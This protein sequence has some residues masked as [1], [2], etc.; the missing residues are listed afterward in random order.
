MLQLRVIRAGR[1]PVPEKLPARWIFMGRTPSLESDCERILGPERRVEAAERLQGLAERLRPEFARHVARIG[2]LQADLVGWCSSSFAWKHTDV[3]ALFRLSCYRLLIKAFSEETSS[4]EELLVLVED[5]WLFADCRRDPRLVGRVVF[6]GN[7]HLWSARA[8]FL[9]RGFAS[10][11]VWIWRTFR[12][13]LL[14]R[15]FSPAKVI[16]N[17]RACYIYSFPNPGCFALQNVWRDPFF[18]GLEAMLEHAGFDVRRLVPPGG[19]GAEREVARHSDVAHPMLLDASVRDIL[20][21]A[22]AAWRSTRLDSYCLAEVAMPLLAEREWWADAGCARWCEY[23]LF[24][25]CFVRFLQSRKPAAVLYPY[26][27]QP[28]EK[29]MCIAARGSGTVTVGYQHSVTPRFFLGYWPGPEGPATPLPDK[30][31]TAG[32]RQRDI[33]IHAGHPSEKISVGGSLRYRYLARAA[34]RSLNRPAG[35][36]ARVLVVGVHN[37]LMTHGVVKAVREAFPDGGVSERLSFSFRPHPTAPPGSLDQVKG[38]STV[39]GDLAPQLKDFD[40]IVTTGSTVAL[41][42]RLQG[43]PVI[44][45]SPTADL[46]ADDLGNMVPSG[47]LKYASAGEMR[48]RILRKLRETGGASEDESGLRESLF[49][50]VNEQAWL[51]AVGASRG[52]SLR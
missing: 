22:G 18:P 8:V 33:L 42:A 20:R 37:P 30:I 34:L 38:W 41:E 26:E 6:S 12:A 50:P 16:D 24:H 7:S 1:L 5:P 2:A 46:D 48:D 45:F 31:L 4:Q 14:Q 47:Y 27:N 13:R 36:A 39:G 28:W 43:L 10:R 9:L 29:L 44:I 32:T 52:V 3:S 17:E 11:A 49:S 25:E 35:A 15:R 19:W 23:R 51:K 21:A 40:L